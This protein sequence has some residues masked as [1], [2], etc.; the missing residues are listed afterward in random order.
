MEAVLKSIDRLERRGCSVVIYSSKT[1]TRLEFGKK[2]L[3]QM[4]RDLR[5]K[6]S[7]M[8]MIEDQNVTLA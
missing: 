6:L 8:G 2:E 7:S 1:S 4:K 5:A 3:S